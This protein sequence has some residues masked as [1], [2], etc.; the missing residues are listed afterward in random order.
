MKKIF[1]LLTASAILTA[2]AAAFAD[3][4]AILDG[5]INEVQGD[6]MLINEMGTEIPAADAAVG[7]TASYIYKDV[8]VTETKDDMISTVLAGT[9]DAAAVKNDDEKIAAQENVV[10]YIVSDQT[11]VF[12]K[13]TGEAKTLKDI[14]AGDQIGVYTGAYEPAV[15]MLPPQLKANIVI[16]YDDIELDSLKMTDADTYLDR[17]GILT[18]AANTLALNID[19]TTEIVDPAG[20]KVTEKD[21]ARKDLLVFYDNSTRSIPAQTTPTKIVVLGENEIALANID[22]AEEVAPEATP[23]PEE[24]PAPEA[25]AT[26]S[27]NV[28]E[29]KVGDKSVTNIYKKG[30][31]D[32]VP[33][34]EIAET[35]GFTVDWDGDLRA[36]MIN[37]GMYSLKIGENSYVKGKMAPIELSA[38]PEITNDLTYV[39]ANYFAE[40]LECGMAETGAVMAITAPAVQ[41]AE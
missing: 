19:D 11:L 36:V 16:I 39:P 28:T 14:K 24:T 5:T 6:I 30:D 8:V 26:P 31:I 9:D 21:F 17:D 20:E 7:I 35:L 2:G 22:A 27:N 15:L 29:I 1:A 33:L 4:E 13:A 3:N 23:A 10:N 34:R 18:N 38:A 37:G 12:S 40:V 32:M 41:N 25:T